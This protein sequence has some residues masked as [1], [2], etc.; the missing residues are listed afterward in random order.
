MK[1]DISNAFNVLCRR[2]TLDVLR[3]KAS[4]DYACGLKEGDNIETVC[5]ELRNM[6]SYFKALRT[7]KCH[8]RERVCCLL[9]LN[10]VTST[11]QWIRQRYFDFCGNVLDAWGKTGG[12]QGD[13][14]EMIAFCLSIHH[15]WGR[16]LAKHYHH[17]ASG[18]R[19]HR[20]VE[21]TESSTNKQHTLSKCLR[22]SLRRRWLHQ[23]Q[24]LRCARGA[25][26]HHARSPGRRWPGP[27]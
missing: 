20:G 15:L 22:S 27:Q 7:T 16:T 8:L 5:T 4:C 24:A 9:V 18:W 11:P 17:A 13:P 3:G 26:R 6:F 14:L 12:Q 25:L 21:V 10:S 23:G 19:I 1:L 2:L